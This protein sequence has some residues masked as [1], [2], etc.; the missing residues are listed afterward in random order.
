MGSGEVTSRWAL[1]VAC[2]VSLVA[3][4]AR[5]Q[6]DTSSYSVEG[7]VQLEVEAPPV[8]PATPPPAAPPARA[9]VTDGQIR[10][11][12]RVY[13]E[14]KGESVKPESHATLDAVAQV[15]LS[16]PSIRLLRVEAHTDAVVSSNQ[17]LSQRRAEW[18]RA[19]LVKHGVA[20]ERVVARG[21][22][23]TRPIATND[24]PEGRALNRRV[25]FVIVP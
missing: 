17:A 15:L 9:V 23:A 22:G 25:E 7:K 18:V 20:P 13:F 1:Y 6:D 21:F 8:A 16:T 2:A 24:T 5:A 3:G 14:S 10:T 12:E 11:L 4:A 19:Y